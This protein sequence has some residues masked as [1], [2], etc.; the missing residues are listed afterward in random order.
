MKFAGNVVGNMFVRLMLDVMVYTHG[1]LVI[2]HTQQNSAENLNFMLDF[3]EY[4]GGMFFTFR[5]L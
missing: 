5:T 1:M 3:S 2:F 4:S